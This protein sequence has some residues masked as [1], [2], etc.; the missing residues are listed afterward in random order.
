MLW[1]KVSCILDKSMGYSQDVKMDL[2]SMYDESAQIDRLLEIVTGQIEKKI[3]PQALAKFT[4]M[5]LQ[6]IF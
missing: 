4:E 2:S 5:S 6:F 1:I 3:K